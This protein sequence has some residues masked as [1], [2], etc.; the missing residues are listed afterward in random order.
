MKYI[1][2]INN[3]QHSFFVIISLRIILGNLQRL[4][5]SFLVNF[6]I[7]SAKGFE[8]AIEFLSL[9]SV[10]FVCLTK[11]HVFLNENS[12]LYSLQTV[13]IRYNDTGLKKDMF[14]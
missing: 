6:Y 9:R 7:F 10:I 5:Q 8:M 12:Y 14:L 1:D 11:V 13:N 2:T 3:I 4:F